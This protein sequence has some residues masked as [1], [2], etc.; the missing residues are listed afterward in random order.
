MEKIEDY[1]LIEEIGKGASCK[2]YLAKKSTQINYL[3][4]KNIR[5][6]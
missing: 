1:T 3:L 6:K 5:K 4:L 2:V